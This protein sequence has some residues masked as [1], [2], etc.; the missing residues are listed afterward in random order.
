MS[1]SIQK[2]AV[3]LS[4][5]VFLKENDNLNVSVDGDVAIIK[6]LFYIMLSLCV[7]VDWYTVFVYSNEYNFILLYGFIIIAFSDLKVGHNYNVEVSL[8]LLFKEA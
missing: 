8:V 5:T 6:I 3:R 1:N 2:T 7:P 4:T